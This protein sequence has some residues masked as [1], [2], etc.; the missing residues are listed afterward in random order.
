[1]GDNDSAIA[2]HDAGHTVFRGTG[3]QRIPTDLRIVMRVRVDKSRS[4]DEAGCVDNLARFAVDRSD[5]GDFA[6]RC[7]QVGLISGRSGTI[8]DPRLPHDE[9]VI[10]DLGV[11]SERPGS[12]ALCCDPPFLSG[13]YNKAGSLLAISRACLVGRPPALI[14]SWL[15]PRLER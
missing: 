10:H 13:I 9:I 15:V 6:A 14:D 1:W 5:R 4:R 8:D 12:E 3:R 11:L 2:D 7:R